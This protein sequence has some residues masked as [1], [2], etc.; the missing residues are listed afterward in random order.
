VGLIF[1]MGNVLALDVEVAPA[2]GAR[3]GLSADQIARFAGE[4]FA[5]LL[6]GA[7][8]TEQFWQR[9]NRQFAVEVREDL[10]TTCFH[11]VIDERVRD[12]IVEL[13]AAGQRVVC[14]TNCI[15]PHYRYHLASGEYA[16]FDRVYASHLMG[17]AKPSPAFFLHILREEGWRASEALFVDDGAANVAAAEAL[18][19]RSFRYRPRESFG[20]LRAWLASERT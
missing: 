18:G 19:I 16:V 20:A 15:E 5:A 2:I 1:D 3:V 10:L 14:G 9:F 6:V 7:E 12:L 13:R 11:P 17:V 4:D 8:T